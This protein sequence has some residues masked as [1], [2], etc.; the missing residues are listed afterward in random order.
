VDNCSTDGTLEVLQPLADKGKIRFIRHDK[1]LE[2]ASSRNTGLAEARG[3]YA[4]FLDSDDIMYPNNLADANAFALQNPKLQVYH[5]LYELVNESGEPIYQYRFPS[6]RNP[7]KAIAE[8]NFMSCIG[9]FISEEVYSQYRFDTAEIL[10]GI[11]DWEFWIRVL[12]RYSVGRINRINSGIVH[13]KGRSITSYTLGS[14]VDKMEYVA[15]KVKSDPEL[16]NVYA[17]HLASFRASCL[18]LMASMANSSNLF[19]EAKAYLRQ[20]VM[21]NVSLLYS[22][23]FHRILLKSMLAIRSTIDE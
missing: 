18:M 14:Y 12:S 7:K 9:G 11:E 8:G 17:P 23:R 2:R 19:D 6:L 10:Q 16:L 4:T 5:N 22:F 3:R 20:A 1:N 13:H 21:I 15:R